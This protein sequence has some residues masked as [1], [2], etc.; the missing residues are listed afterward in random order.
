MAQPI[1]IKKRQMTIKRKVGPGSQA[2]NTTGATEAEAPEQDGSAPAGPTMVHPP[3]PTQGA[4]AKQTAIAVSAILALLT[5]L[6]FTFIL[7]LQWTEL[8]ELERLI[9]QAVPI[10]MVTP[11][12]FL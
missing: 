10:S 8:R 7:F 5:C 9:P 1:T 2:S 6:M 12:I 11:S 3:M 4:R